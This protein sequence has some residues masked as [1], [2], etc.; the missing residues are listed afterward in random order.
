MVQLYTERFI[1]MLRK[2]GNRANDL[3]NIEI[4]KVTSW[5][6]QYQEQLIGLGVDESLAQVCAESGAMDPLMN[7]YVDRMQATMQKWYTNIL[8]ADRIQPPKK[9]EDGK[10]WTPAAV[11]FFRILGEQVQVVTE[12]STDVMLYRIAL[13]VIQV[14]ANFQGAERQRLAEPVA[15]IGLE[16]LC[17]MVNNNMRCYDLAVE[18]SSNVMEALN[19]YYAE[20]VTFEDTCKGFQEIA[21]EAVQQTVNVIFEDPG[22]KEL[23]V[24]LY[25]KDWY[26]GLVTEY[27]VA[28]FGDYFG[29]V[30]LYIEDRSYRR[31]AEACLEETIVIY[32]DRLLSQKNYVKEEMLERMKIDEEILAEFFKEHVNPAKVEKRV[33]TL[34]EIREL[35]SA[36]SVDE[37]T[38]AYTNILQNN[39][40]CPVCVVLQPL[41]YPFVALEFWK[42]MVSV[43][44]VRNCWFGISIWK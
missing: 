8:E 36:E 43:C 19:S 16:A 42:F 38:L 35:A 20:Q 17:A 5:V 44:L 40:D 30:K 4:L 33:Q 10:L 21:K 34:L 1:Q 15:D 14:M 7:A 26:E 25:Q 2:L 6:V 22:V 23:L 24:K 3:S 39:P 11:D 37:F 29:D 28:T 9:S 27:L 32:V 12:N 41:I 18:L 13:A 31:F